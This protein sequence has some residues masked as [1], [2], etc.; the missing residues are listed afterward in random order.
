MIVGLV[1]AGMVLGATA[2]AAA[3]IAGHGLLVA[4]LFYAG[5]GIVSTLLGA[6]LMALF[7]PVRPAEATAGPAPGLRLPGA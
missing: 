2:A 5:A 6:S 1:L 4:F 3:L 7:L